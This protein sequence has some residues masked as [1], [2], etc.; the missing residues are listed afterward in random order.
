[1]PFPTTQWGNI[2]NTLAAT[3]VSCDVYTAIPGPSAT[4]PGSASSPVLGNF[5]LLA[6]GTFVQFLQ[7][8]A[9]FNKSLAGKVA[10]AT[11]WQNNF[12]TIPTAAANDL[13]ICIN[14]RALANLAASSCAW[15]TER[16]LA[17][18]LTL[19]GVAAG[20]IVAASGVAGQLYG[21]TAGTDLQGNM[22]NTVLV[23]GSPA[24]SPVYMM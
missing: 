24:A 22:V 16:G 1:M 9:T 20:K 10:T 2:G 21:A 15:F 11:A 12:V 5:Q 13:V 4:T 8:T 19:N 3:Q 18:P 6:D 7:A 14:D 17:F 23:G